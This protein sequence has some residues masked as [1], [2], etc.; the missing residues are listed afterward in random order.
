MDKKKNVKIYERRK[1]I[2]SLYIVLSI[3]IGVPMAIIG[4]GLDS[5]YFNPW[6]YFIG[7]ILSVSGIGLMSLLNYIF[8]N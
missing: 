8:N 2:S 6:F 1:T 3:L 5:N 7:I 4:S